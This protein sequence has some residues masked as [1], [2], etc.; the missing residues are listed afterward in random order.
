MRNKPQ[1]LIDS[2]N[3]LLKML[4][5]NK[6]NPHVG[7]VFSLNEVRVTFHP[8]FLVCLPLRNMG[9]KE[10]FLFCPP[11]RNIARKQCFLVYPP[12][13]NMA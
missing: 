2:I 6:I 12:F 8:M 5:D 7:R 10:C 11:L 9:R 1:V 3:D 13:G 4:E